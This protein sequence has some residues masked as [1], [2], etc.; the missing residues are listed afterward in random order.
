MG[1]EEEIEFIWNLAVPKGKEWQRKDCPAV[2]GSR[3]DLRKAWEKARKLTDLKTIEL[4]MQAQAIGRKRDRES[5]SKIP[6]PVLI[7]RWLREE[8]W[9]DEIIPPEQ[10][11]EI[12]SAVCQC[13]KPA[14]G[15]QIGK[16]P[17][18]LQR[19]DNDQLQ[20]LRRKSME[21]QGLLPL[22]NEPKQDYYKRC[23]EQ[24]LKQ[25]KGMG[26]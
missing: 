14:L 11:R 22:P 9:A 4:A 20:E 1:I 10:K 15:P 21:R 19:T 8:R 25:L 18:C 2:R 17:E 5:G 23:R 24:A 6:Q 3:G 26:I 13:G 7:G 16:C 12:I